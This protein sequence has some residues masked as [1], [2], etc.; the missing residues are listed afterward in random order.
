MPWHAILPAATALNICWPTVYERSSRTSRSRTKRRVALPIA[1]NRQ[2]GRPAIERQCESLLRGRAGFAV[3]A[4][5]P[6]VAEPC[7]P[8]AG[9]S[10][11][12]WDNDHVDRM[13]WAFSLTLEE[14]IESH[15]TEAGYWGI[16]CQSKPT[17][18]KC[19]S[20]RPAR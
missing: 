6:V 16:R 8:R 2:S 10:S 18:S 14:S 13:I 20:F 17:S 12:V 7:G 11:G 1:W 15:K 3:C 9:G 5:G 19:G 4:C